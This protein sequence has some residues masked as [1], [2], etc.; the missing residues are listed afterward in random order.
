MPKKR[1][2]LWRFWTVRDDEGKAV[3]I[4]PYGDHFIHDTKIN[5]SKQKHIN[6]R[7]NKVA[8]VSRKRNR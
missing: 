8:R 2:S 6:R 4:K 5:P 1:K 7:R 3:S